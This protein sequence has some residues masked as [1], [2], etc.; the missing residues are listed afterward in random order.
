MPRQRAARKSRSRASTDT[1]H[2][3]CRPVSDEQ[4]VPVAPRVEAPD[5]PHGQREHE[6]RAHA[7]EH[8]RIGR[9]LATTPP[10]PHRD[11]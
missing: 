5:V 3:R 9:G 1:G 4:A 7:V 11:L 2:T 8:R 6:V 10:A